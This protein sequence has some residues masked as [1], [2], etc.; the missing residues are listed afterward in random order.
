L[1][2]GETTEEI[3]ERSEPD[4]AVDREMEA[5]IAMHPMLKEKYFGKYVAVYHGELIDYDEDQESLYIR[6][7]E[8]YPEEF[9]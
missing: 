4:P 8:Q 1:E 2:A 5:Y 6:I 9:V 3:I 7:D